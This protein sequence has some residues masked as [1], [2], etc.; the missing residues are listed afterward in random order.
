MAKVE[1]IDVQT[2]MFDGY[3]RVIIFKDFDLANLT[4]ATTLADILAKGKDCGPITEGSPSWDGDESEIEVLRDTE[5]GVIRSKD[6][7]GTFAWSCRI[8]HSK[9]TAMIAG[10]RT[11]TATSLGDGFTL[12]EGKDIIGLNPE[13]MDFRCPVGV[14]NITHNELALFPKGAVNFSPGTDDDDLWQYT[15]KAQGE[16]IKTENLSTLMFIPLGDDPLKV[17]ASAGA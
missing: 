5:G 1:R 6:T 11:H 3:A 13:D 14:L 10:G 2:R 15:L 9:E 7:P 4:S 8:P 16:S 12:A 17:T